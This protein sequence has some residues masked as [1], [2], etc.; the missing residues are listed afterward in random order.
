VAFSDVGAA[1]LLGSMPFAVYFALFSLYC[2]YKCSEMYTL[3][4]VFLKCLGVS[5]KLREAVL[6]VEPFPPLSKKA[7]GPWQTGYDAELDD[8]RGLNFE[9]AWFYHSQIGILRWCVELG[10]IDMVSEVSILSS[11]CSFSLIC[12][13]ETQTQFSIGF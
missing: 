10:R 7:T 11:R 6:N 4:N 5:G 12:F 1:F 9:E 2:L 13:F 8:S 3:D